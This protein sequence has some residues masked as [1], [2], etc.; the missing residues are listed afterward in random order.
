[1]G[2]ANRRRILSSVLLTSLTAF[3]SIAWMNW[4]PR[5]RHQQHN[6]AMAQL[7]LSFEVNRGQAAADAKFVARAG[8]YALLLTHRGESVL[9]L[10]GS[11]NQSTQ[12]HVRSQSQDSRMGELR[13][14][15][16]RGLLRLE[17]PGGNPAP[18]VQGE[19]PL[20]GH[21]NYLIGNDPGKWL[22][23]IP[24]FARVR[25]RE[26]YPGVDVLYYTRDQ[27][28]E[29]DFIVRPGNNPDSVRLKVQ[30]AT[31]IEQSEQ[32]SL[33]LK[34]AAGPV[35][36]HKP[37]AYQQ[38]PDGQREV[39]CNYLLEKGEVRF[40][41]GD[42]DRS[43]VLR[44]DPVLSYAARL[45]AF[46]QAIAVD[47]SGNS[48]LAG[49]TF[50]AN[51][52]TTPGAF[53]PTYGGNGDALIAKLDPTGSTLLFA[54]YLGGSDFDG[55]NSIALDSSGNV[56]VAGSTSSTN[57]PTANAFQSA[58]PGPIAAFVSKL[59]PTGMQ[60]LYS[61]YL[62]GAGTDFATGVALDASG[63]VLVTGSTNSSNFPTSSGA[64]QAAFG[65]GGNDAFIAKVDTTQSG[66]ASLL[67]S[68]YLGGS[69]VDEANAIAV[70]AAGFAFV[71]G[72][73]H[74]AN[75]PTANAFQSACAS[76]TQNINPGPDAFVSKLNA[77]G[78]AL[79][80]STFLG[81]N[82]GNSFDIGR[83]IAVDSIGNAHV[84]G[85]TAS[86]NFPITAGAFQTSFRGAEDAFVTK[87]DAA[88]SALLYSSFIGG[89]DF[90]VAT[91]IA[92]DSSGNAYLTGFTESADFPTVNPL[93]GY[94]GGFCDLTGF[95][96]D[97]CP[98]AI[99]LQIDPSGSTLIYST[100]L[101]GA[102]ENDFGAGIA[103]DAAGNAYVAGTAGGTFPT[104]PGA[105]QMSGGGF[106]A[107]ISP[108]NAPALSFDTQQVNF[109]SQGVGTT[110]GAVAVLLR[111]LGSATLNISSISTSGDFAQTNNCGSSVAAGSNCTVQLTFAPTTL[112][113]HNGMLTVN[114]DAAGSPH[115]IPLSG[116]GAQPITTTLSSSPNPSNQG[117]SVTFTA[118]VTP[119]G[120][121]GQLSFRDGNTVIG[122]ASLN[123]S[124]TATFRLSSLSGG[125]HS[126]TAVYPG[127]ANFTAG[128]STALTQVVNSI[129]L[130]AT[131]TSATV[132]RGGTTTFP[133]TVGQAGALTSP[134]G[135]SCSGLPVGWSCGF[136]P[137]TVPAGSGPTPVTLTLQVGSATAQNL[138]RAPLG[139]SPLPDNAWLGALALLMFGFPLA[140]R[141]R[142]LVWQ[143]S[144]AA[145][146][147]ASLLLLVAG[148]GGGS[149]PQS[150]PAPVTVNITVSATSGSTTASIPFAIAVR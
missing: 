89:S 93:Q 106:A 86:S 91:G 95:G 116:T 135:F 101:G 53:Q 44:I 10:Q 23:H 99:V 97:P 144:A 3:A 56:I 127:D 139:E 55:A 17:F 138:P 72:M 96:P 90:D 9:A 118:T 92:L 85:W 63:R 47:A 7:P 60:L 8:G 74:S 84:A 145:L 141:R 27:Q 83:A 80:Y 61:T 31:E 33:V 133:L 134:I 66:T 75:F 40:A 150:P 36:M 147:L 73:T 120:G 25:Y 59:N 12:R 46:I 115:S 105:L 124:G 126:I 68:T 108:V 114:D 140:V 129:S 2:V 24:H 30:G 70:D 32:G 94:S 15:A 142:N 49:S 69:S 52:P 37:V 57:F 88:G 132:S 45:D 100:Y 76:C 113:P 11:P 67:F 16:E 65:G 121:T 148:C 117:Q 125:S 28:L 34:T 20:P 136:N 21:S 64:F 41:L 111:N 78:T 119:A 128:T 79:V 38:G 103:V 22:T 39:A 43:Q 82:S 81:G 146:G 35:Q 87:L 4:V 50:S 122:S 1:M 58:R 149:D 98:D 107:K 71:T 5:A 19:Q 51:F 26:V 42:Y 62:G 14:T 137:V 29:Y 109:G 130:V 13:E 131:Q 104:T 112:G 18:Q 54:T 6:V 77:D 123:A 143:R 102:G 110:S 48:Y